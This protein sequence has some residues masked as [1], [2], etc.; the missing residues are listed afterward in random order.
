MRVEELMS[1]DFQ[2]LPASLSPSAAASQLAA[3][4][5]GVVVGPDGAPVSLVEAEDLS[6]AALLGGETLGAPNVAL[7]PTVVVGR[8]VELEQLSRPIVARFYGLG[9]RGAVVLGDGGEVVGVLGLDSLLLQQADPEGDTPLCFDFSNGYL[10]SWAS[11]EVLLTASAIGAGGGAAGALGGA[12]TTPYGKVKCRSCGFDNSVAFL[13]NA[14]LPPCR[15]PAEPPHP[16]G[17]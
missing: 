17:L 4:L 1:P 5:Y 11:P 2:L 10:G 15:N 6:R 9:S 13:D 14:H 3:G 16:L 7:P 12:H 8:A